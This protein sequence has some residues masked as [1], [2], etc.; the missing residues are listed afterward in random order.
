MVQ[1]QVRGTGTRFSEYIAASTA[2]MLPGTGIIVLVELV[3]YNCTT[4]SSTPEYKYC[5]IS[6]LVLL[7]QYRVP[8]TLV[9]DVTDSQFILPVQCI[10]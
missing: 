4:S 9:P 10:N 7:Q 3:E 6:Y 8:S 2:G 5:S 1:V